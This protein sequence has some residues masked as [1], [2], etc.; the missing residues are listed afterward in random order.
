[1]IE[2]IKRLISDAIIII[3]ISGG[4]VP[5]GVETFSN[6]FASDLW[7]AQKIHWKIP[8]TIVCLKR[9]N[10]SLFNV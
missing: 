7:S 3:I 2:A 8:P 9:S 6:C 10:I 5:D 1:M 4:N